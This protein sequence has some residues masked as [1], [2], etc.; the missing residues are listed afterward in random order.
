MC[1]RDSVR[2]V[3]EVKLERWDVMFYSER[4]RRSRY[5]VDQEALR[6][7]CPPEAAL[8]WCI[9]LAERMYG[10]RFVAAEVPKWHEE[11]RFY[12]ILDARGQRIAGAYVD[13]Y[14]REG[15]YNHA[16]V[17]G[18]RHGSTLQGRTP[19]SAL[20]TNFDLSLIHI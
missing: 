13:L 7:Y 16:A 20:V 3:D 6:R 1:I 14:P 9:D 2:P 15:K 17:W 4:V 8:A 18:V 10:V 11:V 12:D 5:A 19:I